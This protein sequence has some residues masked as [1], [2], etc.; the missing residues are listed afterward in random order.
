MLTDTTAQAVPFQTGDVVWGRPV[1]EGKAGNRRKGV[2]LDALFADPK[3]VVVWWFGQGAAS[4]DTTTMA[5][6]SELT[7]AGDVWDLG[8][9]RAE[10]LARGCNKFARARELQGL[11][12][13][14]ARRMA[15]IGA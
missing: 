3:V 12:Y 4:M 9:K 13:R 15:S 6:T 14:H 1:R 2:V 7:A 11:L 10:V 5:F 8:S